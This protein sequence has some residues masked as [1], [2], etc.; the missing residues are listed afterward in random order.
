MLKTIGVDACSPDSAQQEATIETAID[1]LKLNLERSIE[2][3]TFSPAKK[4]EISKDRS[5]RS[6]NPFPVLKRKGQDTII[7]KFANKVIEGFHLGAMKPREAL[8][9][10]KDEWLED[11]ENQKQCWKVHQAMTFDLL[12]AR[13]KA[14]ENKLNDDRL[15]MLDAPLNDEQIKSIH[16]QIN[17]L[18]ARRDSL[19]V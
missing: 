9:W 6:M 14:L 11:R 12:N 18:E 15:G 19:D 16:L 7:L 1:V 13:I 5:T 2:Y 10:I 3:H 8:I 17:K 4:K